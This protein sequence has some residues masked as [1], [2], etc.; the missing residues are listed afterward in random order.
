LCG[1]GLWTW[2]LAEEGRPGLK[3]SK[4]ADREGV[5]A[6]PR[7]RTRLANLPAKKRD[8]SRPDRP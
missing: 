5:V 8:P 1:L 2:E 6:R 3:S 7:L 4:R